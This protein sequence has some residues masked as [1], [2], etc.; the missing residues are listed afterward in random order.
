MP[1]GFSLY[2]DAV[3]FSAA[4]LV[5][6]S[7]FSYQSISGGLFWQIGPLGTPCVV[8]F[9]VLSGFVIAYVADAPGASG[10]KYFVARAARVLSVALPAIAATFV[11]DTAGQYYKPGLYADFDSQVDGWAPQLV[12]AAVFLNESWFGH[13]RLGSNGAYW[14]MGYEI[15]YYVAFGLWTFAPPKWRLPGTLLALLVAGPRVAGLFPLWLMGVACFRYCRGARMR[16]AHGFLLWLASIGA[17]AGY[18][19]IYGSRSLGGELYFRPLALGWI[20]YAVAA[21]FALHLIGGWFASPL[22]G[23]A[24]A[25]FA[26]PI[27]AAAGMTFTLYLLH[28]PVLLFLRSISPWPASAWQSRLALLLGVTLAVIGAAQVTEFRR[29]RWRA[30]IERL[31]AWGKGRPLRGLHGPQPKPAPEPA[32]ADPKS[33]PPAR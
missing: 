11:L 7:H 3:R 8:V 24:L 29:D 23:R 21:W 27:R 10:T 17:A 15:W 6:A 5:F 4:A 1:A 20:D 28:Y 31:L 18:L 25:P 26:S 19:W 12:S 32:T 2:L 13:I 9:F 30:G 22:L 16:V 33:L 14:S